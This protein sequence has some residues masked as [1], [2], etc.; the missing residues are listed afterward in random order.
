MRVLTLSL[1]PK[2]R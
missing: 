2:C 1:E